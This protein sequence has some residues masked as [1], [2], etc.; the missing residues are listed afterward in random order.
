MRIEVEWNQLNQEEL[1]KLLF[2]NV[3]YGATLTASARNNLWNYYSCLPLDNLKVKVL[4]QCGGK[5]YQYKGAKI[6]RDKVV[7]VKH[8]NS[9]VE[10]LP[11][12]VNNN[13]QVWREHTAHTELLFKP[14]VK[15]VAVLGPGLMGIQVTTI[16]YKKD[17]E[18]VLKKYNMEGVICE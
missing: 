15:R 8:V 5:L 11:E 7:K 14:Y 17:V 9:S 2:D 12:R 10:P 1:A 3:T 13:A 18:E 4:E 6:Q 16:Q